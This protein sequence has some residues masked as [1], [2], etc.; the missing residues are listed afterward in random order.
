M[1]IHGLSSL[2]V[3]TNLTVVTTMAMLAPQH[4]E[5]ALRLWAEL[6]RDVIMVERD[7]TISNIHD[8]EGQESNSH[9]RLILA[10]CQIHQLMAWTDHMSLAVKLVDY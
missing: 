10:S 1:F 5:M 3:P 7:R 8:L 9:P 6:F 2:D 4:A